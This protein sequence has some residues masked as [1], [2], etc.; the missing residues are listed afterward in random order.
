M[1]IPKRFKLHGQT[2]DVIFEHDLSYRN[3]TRGEA[4]FRQNILALQRGSENSPIPQTHV[5]Q[6]F[7]HELVHFLANA[8]CIED[9]NQDEAKVDLLGSLLHQ[10]L[11]TMEY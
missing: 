9:L 11:S 3:D 7:C 4:R 6:T 5:E 10:A 2:I 8:A 1:K